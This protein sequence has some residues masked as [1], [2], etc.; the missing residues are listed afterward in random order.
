MHLAVRDLEKRSGDRVAIEESQMSHTARQRGIII[1]ILVSFVLGTSVA[2]SEAQPASSP[3]TRQAQGS[4][5]SMK[6]L[7]GKAIADMFTATPRSGDSA[8]SL[9][10]KTKTVKDFRLGSCRP[11]ARGARSRTACPSGGGT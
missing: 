11:F 6:A 7:I 9:W 1:V 3:A 2:R 5:E 10:L 8:L 4:F